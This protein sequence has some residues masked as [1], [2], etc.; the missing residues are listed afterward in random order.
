L[1]RGYIGYNFCG[2]LEF[3]SQSNTHIHMGLGFMNTG[4]L[5]KFEQSFTFGILSIKEVTVYNF[6]LYHLGTRIATTHFSITP[7]LGVGFVTKST[8]FRTEI[9]DDE[10][11]EEEV[12][13]LVDNTFAAFFLLSFSKEYRLNK[14]NLILG[15]KMYSSL[16]QMEAL[17]ARTM[18]LGILVGWKI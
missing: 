3:P 14:M 4:F 5:S 1:Q 16:T 17:E 18:G 10:A 2:K 15:V 7:E 12:S 13:D 11:P 9:I 8:K 6:L